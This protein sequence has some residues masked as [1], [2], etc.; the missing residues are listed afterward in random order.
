MQAEKFDEEGLLKDIELSELALKISKLTFG[1]NNHS[2]PV[3]EA[4]TFLDRVRKLSI[5][6]S[7]YEQRIG[8]N[9]SEYQRNKIYNSMEDLEKL[10]S[11]M[12]NK[13]KPHESLQNIDSKSILNY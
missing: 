4:H 6:I 3:T 5:E 12:K 7:E 8:P 11:Y 13:I 2:D 9:L 10:I 1:W